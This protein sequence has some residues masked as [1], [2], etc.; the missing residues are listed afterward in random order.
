MSQIVRCPSCGKPTQV[1]AFPGDGVYRTC[2]CPT[3]DRL[4]KG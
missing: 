2:G 3:G 1:P 4:A